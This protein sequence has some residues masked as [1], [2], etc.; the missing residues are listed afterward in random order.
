MGLTD[1]QKDLK[2]GMGLEEALI[3]H[4]LTLKEIMKPSEAPKKFVK[5]SNIRKNILSGHYQIIKMINGKTLTFGTYATKEDAEKVKEKLIDVDW[6]KSKLKSILDDL[7]IRRIYQTE[8]RMNENSFIYQNSSGNFYIQKKWRNG[9]VQRVYGGTYSS[10]TEA[11]IIRDEL[12]KQGWDNSNLDE[13][14]RKHGI[15][16]GKQG[17]KR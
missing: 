8:H 7:N 10:I 3:E 4:G 14:C 12:I 1:F 2:N 13:I 5:K 9:K 15:K 11:R 16:R 6:D 17:G